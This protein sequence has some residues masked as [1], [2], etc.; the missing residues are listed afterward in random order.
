MKKLIRKA[1]TVLGSV[2]FVGATISGAA[3]ASYPAPFD[4]GSYAVVYG[5]ADDVSAATT[6]ANGLPATGGSVSVSGGGDSYKLEKTSTKYNL[7]DAMTSVISSTVDDDDMPALLA[8]GEYE[9][10]DNDEFD[11]DQTLTLAASNLTMFSHDDY[12]NDDPSVG[13]YFADGADV[14]TYTLDFTEEPLIAD[15]PTTDLMIMGKEYYVLSSSNTKLTLLD[16]ATNIV[17]REGESQTIAVNGASYEVSISFI[18]SANVKLVV[19]GEVTNSL[20][21]SETY[22]LNDGS[23]VGIKSIDVQD[24]AEGVKQVEFSIGNGKLILE[25]GQDVELNEDT[26]DGL[27]TTIVNDSTALKMSSIS[28]DWDAEDDSFVTEDSTIMMPGFENIVVSF[29]GLIYP[30]KEEITVTY[31]SEEYFQLDNFPLKDSVEDIDLFYAA[32]DSNIILG[33]GKDATNQ[34][35]TSATGVNLTFDSDVADYFVVSWSDGDDSESYLVKASNFKTENSVDKVSFEYKKNGAWSDVKKDRKSGDTISNLGNAEFQIF[36][37]SNANNSVII[38]SGTNTNFNTLYSKEGMVVYLP[39]DTTAV[40]TGA[41]NLSNSTTSF[42]LVVGEEDDNDNLG[43]GANITLTLGYNIANESSVTNVAYS[44]L[45]GTSKEIGNTDIHR[46]FAYSSLATEVLYDKKQDQE[47]VT[48]VYHGSEVE[49]GVY[50]TSAAAIIG[51]SSGTKTFMDSESSSYSGKD[52][53]VVG[54]SCVNSVAA[55]LL[56]GSFCGDAFTGATTVGPGQFLIQSF[57]WNGNIA[58]VVAGYE[59]E[60][61]AKGATFLANEANEVSTDAGDMY[62]GSTTDST[63]VMV[64]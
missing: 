27:T 44:G 37:V 30:E 24:Y 48:L 14:L 33:L 16:S 25:S 35:V 38:Q 8:S 5:S 31:G 19:N 18:N 4:S 21:A 58:T 54:G 2:A 60:D 43:K 55:S 10:D 46:N 41:L 13:F 12:N 17:L 29:T 23:Y 62:V 49:A 3:A 32:A 28:I 36:N 20:A 22:K 26:I 11:Y 9:D 57:D 15:M 59:M 56:G 1:V 52:I 42:A 39:Y 47:S 40:G 34:L 63:A 7:G 61:T 51:G 64:N 45:S 53:V 6:V 50:L